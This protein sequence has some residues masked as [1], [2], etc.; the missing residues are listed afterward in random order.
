MIKFRN[1]APTLTDLKEFM[2]VQLKGN[3]LECFEVKI[4]DYDSKDSK[5]LKGLVLETTETKDEILFTK[6][7]PIEYIDLDRHL[8]EGIPLLP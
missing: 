6:K 4:D 5:T 7:K 2:F 8:V 1:F 3:E